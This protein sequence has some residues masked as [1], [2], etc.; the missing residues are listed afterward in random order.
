MVAHRRFIRRPFLLGAIHLFLKA[1]DNRICSEQFLKGNNGISLFLTTVCERHLLVIVFFAVNA[2]KPSDHTSKR[3]IRDIYLVDVVHQHIPKIINTDGFKDIVFVVTDINLCGLKR[4]AHKVMRISLSILKAEL[5][6]MIA[7]LCL[8]VILFIV[9]TA[10]A[11]VYYQKER[12]FTD[13]VLRLLISKNCIESFKKRDLAA[14]D[15]YAVNFGGECV[16][17][18]FKQ[19]TSTLPPFHRSLFSPKQISSRGFLYSR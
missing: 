5:D 10:K 19:H 9:I 7:N 13:G 15:K 6:C 17:F 18:H 14:R 11:E 1:L 8:G 4:T 2:H 12:R 16:A 3:N